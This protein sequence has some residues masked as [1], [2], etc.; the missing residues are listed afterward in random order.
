MSKFDDALIADQVSTSLRKSLEQFVGKKTSDVQLTDVKL[1]IYDQL[2]SIQSRE[3]IAGFQVG[4]VHQLWKSWTLTQK[5]KWLVANKTPILKDIMEDYRR[6]I[7]D[8]NSL[9][10]STDM[11][12]E[13]LDEDYE[14]DRPSPKILP[15]WLTRSPDSIIV[16]NYT[17]KPRVG[18]DFIKIDIEVKP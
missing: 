10:V 11:M 4:E 1:A 3:V 15:E 9:L 12:A 16:T 5:L 17:V 13:E 18:I 14:E 8:Y 6:A 7:E 2:S